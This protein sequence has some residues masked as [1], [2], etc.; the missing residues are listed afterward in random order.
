ML[1]KFNLFT[2]RSV[3]P[4]ISY[5]SA[6]NISCLQ[7]SWGLPQRKAA[8]HQKLFLKYG[9]VSF[10]VS[11]SE[12]RTWDPGIISWVFI[13]LIS[14]VF[15]DDKWSRSIILEMK[16]RNYVFLLYPPISIWLKKGR[17]ACIFGASFKIFRWF[18]A[19]M[20]LLRQL[21]SVGITATIAIRYQSDPYT[22]PSTAC[23][24]SKLP[25]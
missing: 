6:G 18:V 24:G 11:F 16:L 22:G 14:N 5:L 10:L 9:K 1:L 20:K 8:K 7:S 19:S 23:A 2:E 17:I 4:L 3:L 21:S 15:C 12:P 25:L 13:F